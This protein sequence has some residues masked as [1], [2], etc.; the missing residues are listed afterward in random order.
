M[1]LL[2]ARTDHAGC[3]IA[4]GKSES[5][6]QTN[7][8]GYVRKSLPLRHLSIYQTGHQKGCEGGEKDMKTLISRREF[9]KRSL[10]GTGLTIAAVTTPFGSRLLSAQEVKKGFFNPNVWIRIT[11]DNIVTIVVNKSEM[12]QG[13]STSLPMIAADELDADWN[14]IRF[15]EAPGGKKYIDPNWGMQLTGG[16][17]SVR[18][19]YEPL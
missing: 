2:P 9:L 19:M 15:L 6:G 5:H 13:V 10:A 12:G 3:R 18:H 8:G 17:T 7:Y 14:Q 1:R 4:H 16:S 11:P